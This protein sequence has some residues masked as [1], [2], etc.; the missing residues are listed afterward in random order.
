METLLQK[1]ED[2][3]QM[4]CKRI[5]GRSIGS[6]GNRAATTFFN[7]IISS[8][9]WQT[10][11]QEFDATDWIDGGANLHCGNDSFQV[12]VSPY[13]LGCEA[14]AQLTCASTFDEL[15]KAIITGKI[16]LLHGEIAKEQ[17][18]PKNFVFYNPEEHQRIIALLE[19]GEP[20][21]IICATGRN[22]SLA[23][24]VY[25]FPLIEDGDFD[26]PSVYMTEEEGSRLVPYAGRTVTLNSKSM[27]VPGKG[28]NVIAHKGNQSD[29]RIVITAHID[30]K[31]G[32][33]GAIDNA[34]GVVVLLLLAE[35]LQSYDGKR[36]IEIVALNGEDYYAV[37]GQMLY[38][39]QNQNRFHDILLNI[40]IDGAG[41][42]EG[43]SALSFYG[44]PEE[45][46]G[47][48]RNIIS[49][50]DGIV[51]GSPWVQGDH[52]IFIQNG[53]PAM[54]VSSQWF[55]DHIDSQEITHTLKDNLEIVD[56]GK[57]VEIAQVLDMFIRNL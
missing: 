49:H 25:P 26:I 37:P 27:R 6:E 40:N 32:T 29:R 38:L 7:D 12:F 53:S 46:E 31:K 39:A 23:G 20:N 50:Y 44:L 54:A 35:L 24:G 55:T 2:Y 11:I 16:L 9:G 1:S 36:R 52:S 47:M 15:E 33:P 56:P 41:Y 5:T 48:V 34:S 10:E 45:M 18:M 21:A 13:S 17:L 14:E 43:N 8:L 4:L 3:L 30:A 42:K 19:K 28:C 51:V 22:A 57:L